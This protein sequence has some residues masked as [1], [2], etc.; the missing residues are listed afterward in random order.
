[1]ARKKE[2]ITKAVSELPTN[3]RA[4]LL[5]K[6]KAVC[7]ED[8]FA[9]AAFRLDV[10]VILECWDGVSPLLWFVWD[11]T[12]CNPEGGTHLIALGPPDSKLPKVHADQRELMV[13]LDIARGGKLFSI[14][15]MLTPGVHPKESYSLDPVNFVDAL[16]ALK[17]YYLNQEVPASV[18][19]T[20]VYV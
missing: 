9:R 2:A 6:M 13:A 7:P 17:S 5:D 15:R 12:Y 11:D 8:P 16:K 3:P 14:D 10:R 20:D 19:C 4:A 18:H 1:M